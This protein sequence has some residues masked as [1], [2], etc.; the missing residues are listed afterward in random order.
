MR[1][2]KRRTGA[3]LCLCICLFWDGGRSSK[4]PCSQP[5][6]IKIAAAVAKANRETL[7]RRLEKQAKYRIST[8]SSPDEI[9]FLIF[10]SIASPVSAVPWS[11]GRRQAYERWWTLVEDHPVQCHG[12]ADT[13]QTQPQSLVE[14]ANATPLC[15]KQ[16]TDSQ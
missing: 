4:A 14:A 8:L 16:C 9:E 15:P 13:E 12:S 7:G 11:T 6:C 1:A 2:E 5:K 3:T 10:R